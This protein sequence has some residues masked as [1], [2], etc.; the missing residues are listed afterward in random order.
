MTWLDPFADLAK[1]IANESPN[2]ETQGVRI[3]S[4]R[5]SRTGAPEVIYGQGK[6]GDQ[7]SA[8]IS[9]LVEVVGRAL[10]AWIDVE[11]FTTV[12]RL[13]AG[14]NVVL[15][16]DPI[17]RTLI[18]SV[19]DSTPECAGGRVGLISAGSSD[20]PQIMEAAAV[21]HEMGCDR[22]SVQDVGVAGLHRL[23]TP[24]RTMIEFDPDALIVA[25]GMDG[26]LPGV[27]AGLVAIPI[28]ALPTSTG[29]GFGGAGLGAMTTMLQA[30]APGIAVVNIDNGVGAGV[31]AG[32]IANRAASQRSSS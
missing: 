30:C 11:K 26:V 3:D 10:A 14:R 29:Y 21:L 25:A 18:A 12:E 4:S 32:L 27:V 7:I 16:Y 22:R 6:N 31:M 24:L 17:G 9:R 28:V 8:A 19:A 20:R 1:A 2:D 23:V 15:C 13:L 5:R